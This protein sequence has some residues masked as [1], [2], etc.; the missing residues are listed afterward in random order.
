M[1]QIPLT[2][3][4]FLAITGAG[5]LAS[6]CG[7]QS[8]NAA[9]PALAGARQHPIGLELYAVR[10]EPLHGARD[11]EAEPR[12]LAGNAARSVVK[13]RGT[14]PALHQREQAIDE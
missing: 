14:Q 9:A 4:E 1:D 7:L 6:A 8:G 3:R 13:V 12:Y 5:A 2:R 11:G 10:R